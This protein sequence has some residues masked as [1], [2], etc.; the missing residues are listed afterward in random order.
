MTFDVS[1]M[2]KYMG[3][4][5]A[6]PAYR[7]DGTLSFTVGGAIYDNFVMNY[8]YEFSGKGIQGRSSGTHEFSLG[9]LIGNKKSGDHT[10]SIFRKT[11]SQPYYDWIKE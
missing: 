2:F 3:K 9:F 5:W 4:L 1:A 10:P 11:S 8:S 7:K 6:A